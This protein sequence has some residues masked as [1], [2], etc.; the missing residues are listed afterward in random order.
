MQLQRNSQRPNPS[1]AS[2]SRARLPL[3]ALATSMLLVPAGALAADETILP[4]VNVRDERYDDTPEGYQ[5]GTTRVGKTEQLAKDVPQALSI[6]S[7][8]LIEETNANTL[9]EALRHVSGLTFNAGEGGRIGDNM[10]LRGFYTFGDMYLDGIR[11]VAQYNRETFNLEQVEVLRGSAAML[12]GRGQAGGVINQASKRPILEDR[13]ELALTGGTDTYRRGTADVNYVIGQHVAARLNVMKTDAGSTRDHVTSE[14]EGAAPTITFGLGTDHR[15]TLSHYYLWTHNTPDYGVPFFQNRPLDVSKHTFYGTNQ[16]Y[17]DNRTNMSTATYEFRLSPASTLRS[18]LRRAEYMRDLWAVAPRLASGATEASIA[19]GTAIIN[20]QRQA[21]GGEEKTWTSQTDFTTKF[22]TGRFEH[23][24]LVG[25]ELLDEE[26]GRWSY[27]AIASAV[28]PPTTVRNPEVGPP[29]PAT[30]GNRV[31]T[32]ITTYEGFTWAPY[33]QNMVQIMPGWKLFGGARRD[34]LDADYS[35]GAKVDYSEWSYRAGISHQPTELQHYY[36]AWSDSFSPTADLYQFT[37]GSVVFPAERSKTYEL[38]AKWELFDGDLSLRA[39]AYRAEK[40][41][42]RNT[43][44]ETASANPLLTKKRHT[45]G[46]EL[47]GAGRLTERWELFA[48]LALMRARIDEARPG[49][50]PNVEGMRPRNTPGYSYNLWSTYK[51]D[52]G[53]KIGGGVEAKGERLAYGIGA[54]T[55]PI[56][57]NKVP[58]YQR[59]DAM[60]SYEQRHYEI[61]LNVQ[62][63]FD[64]RY[65]DA[66]YES[67]G[68]VIPGIGRTVQLVTEIKY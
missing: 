50:N 13:A 68:H 32:G 3:G 12:F 19:D 48:G 7:Q 21:R 38:G 8:Q 26:A 62:N 60:V 25:V 14:R 66:I 11:D 41:W 44:I 20:R 24:A 39:S 51:L 33:V 49:G 64:K 17:E 47:E 30:Y 54:G 65:Y 28:A 40:D 10:M 67:G 29:L 46:F 37:P 36:F 31:K 52:H 15:L 2:A 45:N 22:S 63:L 53:W 56:T 23:E 55:A 61:K 5:G 9:K 16:D 6:V 57:P 59:W 1:P 4:Q 43:D 34:A 35:N 42:E 58:S 27:N 18:V